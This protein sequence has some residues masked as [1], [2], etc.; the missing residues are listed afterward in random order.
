MR[1]A[2]PLPVLTT[3]RLELRDAQSGDGSFYHQLLS[4]SDVTRFS[5][6]PDRATR[7]QADRFVE[8]MSKLFGSGSGCAWM[9]QD[10]STGT[11]LG[12]IRINR[13]HK[14]WRWGEIGYESHPEFWGRGLMTE[15]ART[16]IARGHGHFK[17]EPHGSL[18]LAG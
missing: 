18:D 15:A 11:P 3:E 17:I 12:A 8:C 7:A 13:I 10:R 1:Q 14:R 5:D 2:Q 16:V 9:I 4:V 6:L